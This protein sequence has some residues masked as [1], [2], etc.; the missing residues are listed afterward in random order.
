MSLS[1]RNGSSKVVLRV[2]ECR[3][4]NGVGTRYMYTEQLKLTIRTKQKGGNAS[5]LITHSA[6][7]SNSQR[8]KAC[9]KTHRTF[10]EEEGQQH[11]CAMVVGYCDIGEDPAERAKGS[12]LVPGQAHYSIRSGFSL[13]SQHSIR[14]SSSRCSAQRPYHR[15]RPGNALR[16]RVCAPP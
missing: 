7:K 3:D 2:P 1:F 5:I 12:S 11:T 8:W 6:G 9:L 16:W 15:G 10:L 4:H 13:T 14:C